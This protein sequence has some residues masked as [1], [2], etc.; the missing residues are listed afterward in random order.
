MTTTPARPLP[1]ALREATMDRAE[2][3]QHLLSHYP[4]V[5]AGVVMAAVSSAARRLTWR[6]RGDGTWPPAT[7]WPEVAR[8]ADE[9]LLL[10]QTLRLH[11]G[12]LALDGSVR[13]KRSAT[14]SH[15]GSVEAER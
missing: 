1:P 4:D 9:Q 14:S 5:P 3:E 7:P 11:Y 13:S 10:R 6:R 8:A 2:V 15:D 12:A